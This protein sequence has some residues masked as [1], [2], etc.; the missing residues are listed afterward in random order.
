[1]L[2]LLLYIINIY[3]YTVYVGI[4]L[5]LYFKYYID[6]IMIFFLN[7]KK[8]QRNFFYYSS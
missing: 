5:F 4:N 7:K 8:C 2:L 3:K 1:M 6:I